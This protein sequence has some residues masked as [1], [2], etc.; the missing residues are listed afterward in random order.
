[1]TRY[2][3]QSKPTS[4]VSDSRLVTPGALFLA[5]P[6][7]QVDGRDYIADAIQKG[8]SAILWEPRDFEW[9]A[10]WTIENSPVISL[11][12]QASVIAGQFYKNPSEKLWVVGVTGTNGKTSVTQWLG[13]AFNYLHKKTAIIGTLGN[14]LLGDLVQ[15]QNTTPDAILLQKLLADYV[16]Q[17]VEA[18]AME[19]SS[20]GLHQGRVKG[21]HF[22]VAVLTNLSRDHLDY[23]KT[24]ERYAEAKKRLFLSEGLQ[25]AVVN[26]DDAF[27]K[28]LKAELSGLGVSVLTYG[29][30]HGDVNASRVQIENGRINFFVN[31]P[32]GQSDV[33]VRL[34][35]RF[36][37]Y[38]TLAVLATLLVSEVSLV[39]AVEAIAYLQPI[40]GRMQLFGGDY[41]PLVVVDY[42]HTPDSLKNVLMALKPEVTGRL[43]C[44][45]GCGG[46]RDQGKREMMGQVAS[47]LA[48]AVVVTSDNPRSENA[49]AIIQAILAGVNGEY[50]VEENR[51]KAI[52]V[53]IN[54]AKFGDVVLIAGKGHEDY[55]EIAGIKHHFSDAE[56]VEKALRRYEVSVA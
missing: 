25:Y 35:G 49:D 6:G 48:D 19:V 5:Y 43:V 56:E 53:A 46:D 31:T 11:K 10:E 8:A 24:F 52:A 12:Q 16:H 26:E 27:G 28:A 54:N 55:Q 45:F 17:E 3:I 39:D 40:N 30:G 42:A 15:T 44:V 14:G 34:I 9:K 20:H 51:A 33:S 29:I 21:I 4:I 13:Q 37:V 47:E 22:D 7:E 32:Y 18:V 38:N 23:H 2:V 41:L 50:A 36:N 1:M